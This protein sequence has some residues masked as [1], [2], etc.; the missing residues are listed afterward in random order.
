M[1]R[2]P[3]PN[4]PAYLQSIDIEIGFQQRGYDVAETF[5]P[6]EMQRTFVSAYG[7]I[8]LSTDQIIFFEFHGHALKGNVK[9][10]SVLELADEQRRGAAAAAGGQRAVQNRGIVM[11]KTDIN[12]IKAASS[13]IKI[14]SSA[15][16]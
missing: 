9:G 11:E 3:N 13:P 15:K 12:F 14:K 10:T 2:P 16:R 1:P 7:G 4:A 8:I 6:D 5:S